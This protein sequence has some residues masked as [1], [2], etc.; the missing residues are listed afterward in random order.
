[1]YSE[2]HNAIQ[3]ALNDGRKK[4]VIY[5]FGRQG[6]IFK[7]I[8]NKEYHICE[9]FIIDNQRNAEYE[10][11]YTL[12]ELTPQML[13]RHTVFLVSDNFEIYF[14]LRSQLFEYI[15]RENVIDVLM[16]EVNTFD[17]GM[18]KVRKAQG[19]KVIFNQLLLC[20]DGKTINSVG[21]NIGNF[22]YMESVKEMLDYDIETVITSEWARDRLGTGNVVSIMPASNF[23]SPSETWYEAFIP[24]FENTDMKFTMVGLGAQASFDETPKDIV[25]KLSN[26]QKYFFNL[27]SEHARTIGVRG[28]FTAECLNE[29]GIKN[30]EV[31]GCPSFYQYS[32]GYPVLPAPTIDRILYNADLTKKKVYALA[33]QPDACLI[34]QTNTD[35]EVVKGQNKSFDNFKDWN[36]F[37]Q[38]GNFTFAFGSRFHGNMMALRNKIPTVWVVHDWR[39]L[40]L[41]RYLGLPHINYYDKEFQNMR[42]VEELLEYCNYNMVY[43]EYPKLYE[44]YRQFIRKN[45]DASF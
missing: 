26:K 8:L 44:K 27:A 30:V 36:K 34:C 43:Q 25:S 19:M 6:Q 1:M 32:S 23:I 39:T 17:V 16:G 31:I 24:V 10:Q 4:F 12:M 37:I 41:V 45:Y 38:S 3:K 42:H 22:V 13:E 29:I 9:E 11:I 35:V 18:E 40:E 7:Q 2:M 28:E 14:Q 33:E 5:P 21:E 20:K 15:S